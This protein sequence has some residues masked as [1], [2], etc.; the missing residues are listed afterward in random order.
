MREC[1]ILL[2]V[3][4]L[5]SPYGIG[6]FSKEAYEW[7]DALKRAG[8]G[9]WQVLPFGPTGYGIRGFSV[10]VL[11]SFAGNPY[12]I[13]LEQLIAEGLLTKEEC[14][15]A[16]FG[17]SRRYIS[18]DRIYYERFPLLRKAYERWKRNMVGMR[19]RKMGRQS[20]PIASRRRYTG[21][22]RKG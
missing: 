13:D 11:S 15:Q 5:P 16:D 6:A 2:P 18:Y 19:G 7:A 4:S 22:L 8:Q 1:G 10:P 17:P 3:A 9:Y 14:D 12:F 21:F 20:I